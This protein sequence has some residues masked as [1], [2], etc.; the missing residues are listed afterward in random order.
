MDGSS[1]P[2]KPRIIFD[3]SGLNAIAAD[4]DSACLI[5]S[6]S[7]GF[8]PRITETCASEIAATRAR[9][10]RL[11]L[12]NVCRRLASIGDCILPYNL[13]LR[14]MARSHASN[15]SKFGWRAVDI[16]W[17]NLIVELN[18]N[19]FFHDDNFSREAREWNKALNAE[20]LKMWRE[21]RPLAHQN[22]D[23]ESPIAIEDVFE[24]FGGD[25]SPGWGLAAD[26]Y[27][28][29][30]GVRLSKKE[31]KAFADLCPPMKAALYAQA[32]GQYHWAVKPEVA[33][34]TYKA[35]ALD[36]FSGAYLPFC[37]KFITNDEGQYHALKLVTEKIG[38]A[39]EVCLYRDF[40]AALLIAC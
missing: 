29:P 34:A 24:V 15:P 12:L 4:P 8:H 19:E 36:L 38:L 2:S 26:M 1:M 23:D 21:V 17:S 30:T 25:E 35:G 10:A 16:S 14:R 20:Y 13:I 5:P 32:V 40:V 11:R 7:E 33:P 6:L 3:T 9:D 39:T 37:E 28:N 27:E 22:D 31:A 18:K